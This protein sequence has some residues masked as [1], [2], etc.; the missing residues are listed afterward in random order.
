MSLVDVVEEHF[1]TLLDDIDNS[2]ADYGLAIVPKPEQWSMDLSAVKLARLP[3]GGQEVMVLALAGWTRE[4]SYFD[5]DERTMYITTAIGEDEVTGAVSS[6]DIMG[7]LNDKGMLVYAKMYEYNKSVPE[8]E[9]TPPGVTD[10]GIRN[11][12]EKML[13]MNPNLKRKKNAEKN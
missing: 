5:R 9:T 13:K 6:N 4:Q 7:I 8:K 10:E 12:M 1:L 11:S 3:A 2:D